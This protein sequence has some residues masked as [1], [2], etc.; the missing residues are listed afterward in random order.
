MKIPLSDKIAQQILYV[1]NLINEKLAGPWSRQIIL[2]FLAAFIL[3]IFWASWQRW[4]IKS[5]RKRM[6]IAERILT[7]FRPENGLEKILVDFLGFIIPLVE[8][9]GYYFYLF[10]A[11]NGNYVLK[12]VRHNNTNMD[13]I[14]P[15]YSGLAP[16]Q[17][18]K[19]SPPLT[20]STEQPDKPAIVKFGEVSM[21]VLPMQGQLGLI[22]VGPVVKIPKRTM[23]IMNY[24]NEHLH[25]A[26]NIVVQMEKM[27]NQV[28]AITA[29]SQAIRS[30]TKSA[31]DLDGSISAL[32]GLSIKI[33]DSSGG[34]FL[35][36]NGRS[37]ELAVTSGLDQ[38]TEEVFRQD[39]EM[40]GILHKLVDDKDSVVLTRKTED[41]Y[42]MP[43]YFSAA[44]IQALLILKVSRREGHDTVVYWF[45]EEPA[46]EPHRVSALQTLA[47]RM[48]DAFDR[49]L[50]FKEMSNSY[51]DTLKILV[52]AVDNLEATS[53]G[54]SELI[55]RYSG[56]I[57]WELGLEKQEI[58]DI[59]L[60][61]Y[62]HDVGMLGLSGE[63]LFKEGKY[64]DLEHQTMKLH[65]DVGAGIIESTTANE[66]VASY[67]RHHHERWDGA[68]YPDGLRG[69][70]I[71]LGARIIAAADMF[72][73]KLAG[74]KNREPVTFERA[75]NDL[76][77][78][79]GTQFDPKIRH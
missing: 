56:I 44:G 9:E 2:F 6:E 10:D 35:L 52:N 69:E 61:G 25:P 43:F 68:G 60:A 66:T 38:E 54:H 20:L 30:L 21:L 32:L 5:D 11:K 48:G 40:H 1:I 74:R 18:E 64:T 59:L 19:Y 36:Y 45:S 47:K 49:Q 72:N 63:I 79:S 31:Y 70:E 51:L 22:Q 71:P 62:L 3:I 77:A 78:A 16:Y 76:R 27:R 14:A 75:I 15:S 73:A 41:F 37:L 23:K 57:A 46:I 33:V 4:M 50:K 53:V 65:A 58:K 39:N 55:S 7:I 24:L 34:C 8:A 13:P 26:L 17:K 67:I 12:A 29:S 42:N 28:G